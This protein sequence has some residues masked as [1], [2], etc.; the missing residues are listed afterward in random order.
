MTPPAPIPVYANIAYFRIPRFEAL[1]VGEQAAEKE[2]LEHRVREAM[3]WV[4]AGERVVLDAEE[5]M[6]IVMFGEPARA[7][8][9]VQAVHRGEPLHAG[10]N[11]GPLAL[12]ARGDD[13]RV[14][15]DGLV[16]AA[17]AARFS[18]PQ[19]LLVT[20]DFAKAL[21]ATSPER[22][23][24][25]ETAGEFTDTRVRLHTFFTPDAK[26]KMAR[27]R[28]LV[29]TAV[30]GA[31]AILFAGVLVR[32]GHQRLFP[33]VVV[34]ATVALLIKPRGEIVVDGVVKGRTPPLTEIQ[35]TP[36]KHVLQIRS[37]GFP[38]LEMPVD[39]DA[40]ERV[41][42]AHTFG[43]KAKPKPPEPEPDFWRDL[44]RKFGGS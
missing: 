37:Q 27:R 23:S 1:P 20:Q 10:V 21:E 16:A 43:T 7:L 44:R 8:D 31:A 35:L 30:L 36:G 25:L 19:R 12:T 38:T 34:P 28:N 42:L 2:K 22:A 3:A 40:G 39:L 32:E 6:A 9:V 13:A 24:E 26:R 11:Y 5:G 15:G 33:P 4:A 41:T 14:F 18:E 17:A 29:F